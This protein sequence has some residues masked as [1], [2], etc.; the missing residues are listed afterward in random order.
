MTFFATG[1]GKSPCDEIG[2]TIKRLALVF[3]VISN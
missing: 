1:Y 3:E 2:D